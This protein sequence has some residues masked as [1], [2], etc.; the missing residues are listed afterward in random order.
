M[1]IIKLIPRIAFYVVIVLLVGCTAN[2]QGKMEWFKSEVDAINYGIKSEQINKSDIIEEF[3]FQEDKFIIFKFN[4]SDGQGIGISNLIEKDRK[5]AWN[6]EIQK[7]LIKSEKSNINADAIVKGESGNKYK[8]FLGV[9]KD[10]E[11]TI[12]SQNGTVITPK[13]D[14]ETNIF[15]HLE[16]LM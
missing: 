16:P 3:T 2:G 12:K 10:G 7:I 6:R 15:Y 13:I 4:D 8:L 1:K 14:K 5:Y 11:S 9:M